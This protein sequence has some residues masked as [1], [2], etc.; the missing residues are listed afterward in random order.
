MDARRF[1]SLVVFVSSFCAFVYFVRRLWW[2]A[3]SEEFRR[4]LYRLRGQRR[5][6]RAARRGK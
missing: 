5:M 4:D 6:R 1:A 3:Q 2:F